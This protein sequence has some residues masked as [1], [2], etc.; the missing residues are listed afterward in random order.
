MFCETAV[1]HD[2]PLAS[3]PYHTWLVLY[4][5]SVCL[6]YA[7]LTALHCWQLSGAH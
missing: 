2:T 1:Q 4:A 5:L 3:L 7:A 6:N